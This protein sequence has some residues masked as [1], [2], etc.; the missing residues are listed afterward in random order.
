MLPGQIRVTDV[1]ALLV[2]AFAGSKNIVRIHDYG[3]SLNKP[4]GNYGTAPQAATCCAKVTDIPLLLK[5]CGAL[6]NNP[7]AVPVGHCSTSP[8]AASAKGYADVAHL[9][10]EHSADSN[11]P[12]G[13]VH[14]HAIIAAAAN[15]HVSWVDLLVEL[16][17][18]INVCGG[19]GGGGSSGD[20]HAA[21]ATLII[22]AGYH[23][24][25]TTVVLFLEHGTAVDVRSSD[26]TTPL[27]AAASVLDRDGAALLLARGAYLHAANALSTAPHAAATH[28]GGDM[29]VLLLGAGAHADV[30]RA[31]GRL[32]T[33]LHAAALRNG[34]DMAGLMLNARAAVDG[35]GGEYGTALLLN[36]GADMNL[37]GCGVS[38][39]ALHMPAR[40]HVYACCSTAARR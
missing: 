17:A 21:N 32:G 35:C 8:Q 6:V 2:A 14:C 34:L 37:I 15:G 39:A 19:G 5:E 1:T 27:I 24:V 9:L 23:L 7:G 10:L 26:G 16:G 33:Q 28:G 31:S 38:S 4:S 22:W 13:G 40:A 25:S 18:D 3:A 29:C 12:A 11:A 30:N 20:M 36:R